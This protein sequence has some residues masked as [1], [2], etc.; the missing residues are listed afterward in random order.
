MIYALIL[1][2]GFGKR[3]G[4]IT[5]GIPKPMLRLGDIPILEHIILN[6]KRSGIKNFIINLHY[7]SNKITSYFGNGERLGISIQYSYEESPLGTAGALKKVED[8]L[9]NA[10]QI[11]VIYGDVITNQNFS[12]LINFHKN[13]KAFASIIVHERAKSNS[14]VELDENNK[15][16]KF[17]ER[18][19][20]KQI[21]DKK[22]NWVNSGLYLFNKE[23]FKFI[24]E[25]KSDFPKDIFQKLSKAEKLYGFPLNGYRCA[26]DSPERFFMLQ[27]DYNNGLI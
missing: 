13:K 11:L 18:P 6:L 23:I 2:A 12:E 9:N 19:T 16:V 25:G 3:L 7:M 20:E 1:C 21:L 5:V 14:I 26:I 4:D 10:D 27:C 8:K 15:I 24:P 22:Q 17:I